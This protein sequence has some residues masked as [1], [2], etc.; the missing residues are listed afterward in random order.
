MPFD[1]DDPYDYPETD[2]DTAPVVTGAS[3]TERRQ[4]LENHPLLST[5]HLPGA[6]PSTNPLLPAYAWVYWLVLLVM[7]PLVVLTAESYWTPLLESLSSS[8]LQDADALL[9]QLPLVFFI[10]AAVFGSVVLVGARHCI[11]LLRHS[12]IQAWAGAFKRPDALH[13]RFKP[14]PILSAQALARWARHRFLVIAVPPL[15]LIALGIVLSWVGFW[16]MNTVMDLTTLALPPLLT[17]FL[18]IG[19]ILGLLTVL[20]F[21]HGIWLLVTTAFGDAIAQTEPDLLPQIIFE[22]SRRV[23]FCSPFVWVLY[24]MV[25]LFW[26][27]VLAAFLALVTQ[28]DMLDV[29]QGRMAWGW[30]LLGELALVGGYLLLHW[31]SLF[32]YHHALTVYYRQLPSAFRERF[33]PPED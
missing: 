31:L 16:V 8:A 19:L 32:C 4:Q 12:Y 28:Y 33:S 10:K 3:L 26:G 24:P 15:T 18:F 1:A 29:L 11:S 14:D 7:T 30:V 2:L 27:S 5:E 21:V 20:S 9:T 6:L 13:V 23:A 25:V 17:L 22:R